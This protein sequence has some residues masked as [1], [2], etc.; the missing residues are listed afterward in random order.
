[1]GPVTR[2]AINPRQRETNA[3]HCLGFALSNPH[4]ELD[5]LREWH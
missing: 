1:M 4:R 3:A 5:V 2:K